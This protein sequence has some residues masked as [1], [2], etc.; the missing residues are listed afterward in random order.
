MRSTSPWIGDR[1]GDA[2]S[3]FGGAIAAPGDLD[4]DE[5]PDLAVGRAE[6]LSG[7]SAR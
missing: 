1:S 4:G 3:G 6:R 5:I 7:Q 2:N